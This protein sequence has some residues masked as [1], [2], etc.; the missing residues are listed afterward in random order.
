MFGLYGNVII[1]YT[2]SNLLSQLNHSHICG[3]NI[4]RTLLTCPPKV[5]Q[6]DV[7]RIRTRMESSDSVSKW[8]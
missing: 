8:F 6:L 5:T 1:L 4:P 3:N 7:T 2:E